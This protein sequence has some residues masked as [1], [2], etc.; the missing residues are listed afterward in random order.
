MDVC[1]LMGSCGQHALGGPAGLGHTCPQL[2]SPGRGM[3]GETPAPPRLAAGTMRG[4][5]WGL[6]T[7]TSPGL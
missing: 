1:A 5:P 6:L 3:A 2:Q 4:V 7:S